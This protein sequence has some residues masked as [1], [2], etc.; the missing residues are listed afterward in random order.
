MAWLPPARWM[1]SEC[2][3]GGTACCMHATPWRESLW[4]STCVCVQMGTSL[5]PR[6]TQLSHLRH[7]Q[8]RGRL[9]Q[10]AGHRWA[11]LHAWQH[12]SGLHQDPLR[13]EGLAA[14]A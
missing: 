7:I 14:A 3:A 4:I 13:A 8:S 6:A 11:K 2:V 1:C 9:R 12:V 5:L 10:V